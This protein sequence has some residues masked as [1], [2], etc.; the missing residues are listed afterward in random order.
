[1]NAAA[2]QSA[3][4][5]VSSTSQGILIPRMTTAQRNSISSATNSLMIFNID[6]DCLQTYNFIQGIWENI[7]CLQNCT[8]APSTPGPVDGN[9]SPCENA[10]GVVY[11]IA[12]VSGAATYNWTVPPGA[13]ITSGQGTISIT[14]NFTTY[15][16]N[17]CVT[18]SNQCGTSNASCLAIS[19]V[20]GGSIST[21]TAAVHTPSQTQIIWNWNA[22]SGASGY[23]WNTVNVYS[24]AIDMG[25]STSYTET[26]LSCN[27]LYTR[28]VWAY[29]GCTNSSPVSLT[30]CCTATGGTITYTD[31]S[32]L[33]PRVT[34]P[35][36]GGYI[37]HTFSSSGT[38]TPMSQTCLPNVEALAV[39]GGGGG[40]APDCGSG[41]GGG[42]GGLVYNSSYTL[43]GT[44][45]TA[46]VG[47]GGAGGTTYV[48]S[49]CCGSGC[50]NNPSYQGSN[51]SNSAFGTLTATGGGG[52]GSYNSTPHDGANGGCGGG[53]GQTGGCYNWG[54]S[55]F[56]GTGSQG[57]NGGSVDFVAW[58]RG[59][60]GGGGMGAAGQNVNDKRGGDGG[61]GVSYSLS[62]AATYYAGGGGGSSHNQCVS[63]CITSG[64]LGGGGNGHYLTT[65]ATAGAANTG[66]GGGGAGEGVGAAGSSG[67]SG[68]ILVRYHS[69]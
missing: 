47:N 44:A 11:A 51:G 30:Q 2:D 13:T 48:G 53:G 49:C 68:I 57:Y 61:V 65:A 37:V 40:G 28:Y 23:K 1:M 4:L 16:G 20:T 3:L 56:G 14:V 12:A 15:S 55:S 26:N 39:G 43:N 24:T 35:Y 10:T 7:Y 64:G 58:E 6:F 67:G 69:P 31:A 42:A 52:G 45:V 54:S 5:D 38:F 36:P 27:I 29:N 19:L 32:G 18:A 9:P 50:G 66:G 21:P 8:A 33:N 59:G 22:V 17:V 62:G 60:G 46:T 41:G 25:T 34:P 63:N